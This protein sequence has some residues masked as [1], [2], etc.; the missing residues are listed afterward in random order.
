M[1]L[2]RLVSDGHILIL[3]SQRVAKASYIVIELEWNSSFSSIF[4]TAAS[5]HLKAL[6]KQIMAD[7]LNFEMPNIRKKIYSFL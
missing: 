2:A 5:M 6:T 7:L 1:Q 4:F 3:D